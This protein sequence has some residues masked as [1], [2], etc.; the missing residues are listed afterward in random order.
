MIYSDFEK[1]VDT[2]FN[3]FDM[4]KLMALNFNIYEQEDNYWGIEIIGTSSFDEFDEDWACDEVTNFN[5]RNNLFSWQEKVNFSEILFK[6]KGMINQYL[7]DG[8]YAQQMKSLKGIGTGFVDG[9][10]ELIYVQ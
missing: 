2:Y 9:N 4:N 8:K 3:L 5:T 10:I 6:T 1:W 7:C